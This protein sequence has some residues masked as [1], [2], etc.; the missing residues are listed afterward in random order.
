M[1]DKEKQGESIL[2]KLC[3]IETT[4]TAGWGFIQKFAET[5]LRDLEKQAIEEDDDTKAQGLRR[6][7]RGARKFKEE[8][9]KRIEMAKVV[10]DQPSD[11]TF[12]DVIM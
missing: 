3:L 12:L 10:E 11:D 2:M 9:F 5:V 7:A 1:D 6:D 8:L 4:R